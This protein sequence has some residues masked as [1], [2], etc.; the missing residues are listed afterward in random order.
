MS[1]A[2]KIRYIWA[3]MPQVHPTNNGAEREWYEK[4]FD[5]P[6]YHRLYQYRDQEEAR[7]FIDR[8]LEE[9]QPSPEARMLDLACGKGRYSRYLADKG[10]E[11]TGIDLSPRSIEYACRFEHEGLSFYTHDM[12]HLFRV[13]YYDYV[14]NFFTSFGYFD[15]EKDDLKALCNVAKGLKPGGVFVLDFF[16]SQ[17]VIDNLTGAETK[18]VDGIRFE[19]DKQIEGR[20]VVKTINFEDGGRSY[21]FRES[22]R[23]FRYEDFQ[24][25]FAQAGL[26]IDRTYGDYQLHSFHEENSPRLIL[27]AHLP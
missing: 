6:Y 8:L 7:Q 15:S 24:R 26:Q 1:I 5:S 20:R 21:F 12:R 19:I 4:W 13:N 3:A 14:F 10:F 22:V 27:V 17:Y 18:Y 9:L 16:N 23:L 25:L 11:V 2:R